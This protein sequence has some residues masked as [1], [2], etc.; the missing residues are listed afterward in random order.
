MCASSL[1]APATL[2]C[3][4]VAFAD[5]ILLN[6]TD[7]VSEAHLGEVE[8]ALRAINT[9]ASI[10]RTQNSVVDSA[11]ASHYRSAR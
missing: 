9:T 6:K 4:E 1:S 7:L 2:A 3:P 5:R 10:T 11:P 8:R